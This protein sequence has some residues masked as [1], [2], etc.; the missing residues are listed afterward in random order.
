MQAG[1]IAGGSFHIAIFDPIV[2]ADQSYLSP[3]GSGAMANN[4]ISISLFTK[5][6]L[7]RIT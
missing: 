4:W 7:H 2:T 3:N 5:F 1:N 6:A